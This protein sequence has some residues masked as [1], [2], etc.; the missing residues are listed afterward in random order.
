ME[1]LFP[2]IC[3]HC[4]GKFCTYH[5]LP[6]NHH[7]PNLPKKASPTEARI[8][9]RKPRTRKTTVA[10]TLGETTVAPTA[11]ET[12]V[13]PAFENATEN[14]EPPHRRESIGNA[15]GKE[16]R[17]R[18]RS[19]LIIAALCVMLVVVPVVA[20]FG[21]YTFGFSN[22]SDS[23]YSRG[24][25]V[26]YQSGNSSGYQLGYSSGFSE[27]NGTG[28]GSGHSIGFLDGNTSGFQQG[29]DFGWIQ[30]NTSGFSQGY[31]SGN[32][33]GYV[34]GYEIGYSYG[35]LSGYE[36]GY[37]TGYTLGNSSGFTNGFGNGYSEGNSSGYQ[38]GY[39]NGL[40][41]GSQSGYSQGFASGNAAGYQSGYLQGVKDGAGRG[42]TV[43]DPTYQEM[44]SFMAVDKTDLNAYHYPDYVCWNFAADT[45][46]NA[47]KNEYRC[48]FVYIGFTDGYA[49]AVICFNTTDHEL[50]F[51]EPQNDAIVQIAV[52]SYYTYTGE[53][54][55][56]YG[57]IW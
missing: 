14:P 6:E 48:G 25:E 51:I 50:V 37:Q 32:M 24:H 46:N 5:K 4:G 53:T 44:I 3:E 15:K 39:Q 43:R 2:F 29:Q 54:I 56:R 55:A 17:A 12:R 34:R 31:T 47:F 35:N 41:S 49:H 1:V 23:G 42:Y 26:G 9:Q 28:Y 19:M 20:A 13:E 45:I 16:P 40:S 22:G 52:G 30:G 38:S 18:K 7:C 11:R 21:S 33:S 27:G 36:S 10:P 8:T 57:I